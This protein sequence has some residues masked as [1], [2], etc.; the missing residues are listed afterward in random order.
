[1]L[2]T[3]H[4]VYC[5]TQ[6]SRPP[7]L[8]LYIIMVEHK[9][10]SKM[11]KELHRYKMNLWPVEHFFL[12]HDWFRRAHRKTLKANN[13]SSLLSPDEIYETLNQTKYFSFS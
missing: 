13:P 12:T 8:K 5:E 6:Q 9:S 2:P 7:D 4:V 10:D 11:C 1:M 3:I